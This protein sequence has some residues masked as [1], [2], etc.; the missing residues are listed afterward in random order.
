ML[1][2]FRQL[3]ANCERTDYGDPASVER[4][5][6]N[7]ER[8]QQIVCDSVAEN[9]LDELLPLLDDVQTGRWLAPQLVDLDPQGPAL[10]NRC[11]KVLRR[12]AEDQA[13]DSLGI[14]MWLAERELNE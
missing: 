12:I 8:M 11:L 2:Q 1:N 4:H 13:A 3:A 6:Q 7:V 9:R 10:K 14:K 5:N